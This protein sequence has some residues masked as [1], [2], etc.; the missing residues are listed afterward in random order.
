MYWASRFVLTTVGIHLRKKNHPHRRPSVTT[1]RPYHLYLWSVMSH[2]TDIAR[3]LAGLELREVL[4][5]LSARLVAQIRA[6]RSTQGIPRTEL[7]SQFVRELVS[8]FLRKEVY[9]VYLS[10]ENHL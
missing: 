9:N 2:K 5:T 6:F 8:E 1:F 3:Y 10:T 7:V 4:R